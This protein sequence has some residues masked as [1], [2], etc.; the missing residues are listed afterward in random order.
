MAKKKLEIAPVQE[1]PVWIIQCPICKRRLAEL[2]LDI[3]D[4]ITHNTLMRHSI[5]HL[6]RMHGARVHVY[7]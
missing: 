7:V 4:T 1:G 6:E 2:E 3:L 5:T